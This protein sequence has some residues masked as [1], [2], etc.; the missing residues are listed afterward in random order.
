MY[1]N[2]LLCVYSFPF[3]CFSQHFFSFKYL[4]LQNLTLSCDRLGRLMILVVGSMSSFL[5]QVKNMIFVNS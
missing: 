4:M 5:S 2:N 3:L 1:L